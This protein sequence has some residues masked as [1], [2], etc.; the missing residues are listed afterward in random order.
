MTHPDVRD[1]GHLRRGRTASRACGGGVDGSGLHAARR[2]AISAACSKNKEIDAVAIHD[3]RSLARD[4]RRCVRWR[5]ART[6]SSRSR[7]SYSVAEGRAM[8]DAS[9]RTHARHARWAI[10]STTPAGTTGDVVEV[11]QSGQLGRIKRVHCWRTCEEPCSPTTS[12]Q[13]MPP[14]LDYD[15]WLGPAPKRRLSAA[16]I[17]PHVPATSGTI[18]EARSSISGA[19][20]WT[21]PCG[22]WI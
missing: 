13:P 9:T 11:V 6:S 16:A 7:S 4:Y 8:A 17:A 10:T 12:L 2:S 3:S 5:P 21:W 15:F 14:D 20:S 19:T 22:R 1:R 18:R